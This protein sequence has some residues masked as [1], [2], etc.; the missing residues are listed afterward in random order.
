MLNGIKRNSVDFIPNYDETLMEPTTLPSTFPN[1]LCNPNTGIGVAIACNWA[2]HNLSEVADCITNYIN[3]D[4]FTLP[5]P[6]FPTGG[7][8][9]N[10]NDIPKIMEAFK[11]IILKA[12]GEKSPDGRRF[13]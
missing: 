2:P 7:L 12:Y 1:L 6:D 13:I 9:I 11:T 4:S 3:G 8:V 10:K 5:G